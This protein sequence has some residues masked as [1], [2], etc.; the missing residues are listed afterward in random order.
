MLAFPHPWISYNWHYT[1][2][3][4]IVPSVRGGGP[5]RLRVKG[6]LF[7]LL[8]RRSQRAE[9]GTRGRVAI[10]DKR[11]SSGG[12]FSDWISARIWARG[13][14]WGRTRA[15]LESLS[16]NSLTS[17]RNSLPSISEHIIIL[18]L[19]GQARPSNLTQPI[20]HLKFLKTCMSWSARAT[21][22]A[23]ALVWCFH[24][25]YRYCHFR[26]VNASA[27][28][29]NKAELNAHAW[30]LNSLYLD[31]FLDFRTAHAE[32]SNWLLTGAVWSIRKQ[33]L[34]DASSSGSKRDSV[35]EAFA[36]A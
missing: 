10:P 6:R 22:R 9:S 17:F 3:K 33:R 14:G 26:C 25:Q 2:K 18:N 32:E 36:C 28:H 19:P 8:Y 29:A 12:S 24:T 31:A 27:N 7:N 23:M 11:G 34:T 21:V 13:Q 5:K 16:S 1:H 20:S 15:L 30:D 35:T 4:K